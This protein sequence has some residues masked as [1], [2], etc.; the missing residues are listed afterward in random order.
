[1]NRNSIFV[2]TVYLH[3]VLTNRISSPFFSFF[4]PPL[5]AITTSWST[6]VSREKFSRWAVVTILRKACFELETIPRLF[7]CSHI[8]PSYLH[9]DMMVYIFFFL[10][11]FSLFS[12]FFPSILFLTQPL[13]SPRV[14]SSCRSFW[15]SAAEKS[16]D[17]SDKVDGCNCVTLVA[18]RI[19][20]ENAHYR[21]ANCRG[22]SDLSRH[23]PGVIYRTRL[24]VL[25]DKRHEHTGTR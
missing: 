17:A 22:K 2:C 4:F 20:I 3:I 21:I 8:S 11:F 23:A 15:E 5:I 10:L 25:I 14:V 12:F 18:V 24:M 1:M 7:Q 16:R 9:S 6:V 13:F 19:R